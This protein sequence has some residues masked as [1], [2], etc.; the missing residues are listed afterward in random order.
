MS[1]RQMRFLFRAHIFGNAMCWN[2]LKRGWEWW[3]TKRN[4]EMQCIIPFQAGSATF[5]TSRLCPIA[6]ALR[7]RNRSVCRRIRCPSHSIRLSRTDFFW[8]IEKSSQGII[9]EMNWRWLEKNKNDN[10]KNPNFSPASATLTGKTRAPG[11]ATIT[12]TN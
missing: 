1:K 7:A 12:S 2:V 9:Q 6:S 5:N 8:I 11:P 3:E 10:A 4:E